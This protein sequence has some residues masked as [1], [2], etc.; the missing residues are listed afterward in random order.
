MTPRGSHICTS[1]DSITKPRPVKSITIQR[2]SE[3]PLSAKKTSLA[4][5]LCALC[6]FLTLTALASSAQ[7]FTTL[8]NF[9]LTDGANP[10]SGSLAQ[11]RD[12]SFYGT[13]V[14]GG[15]NDVGTVFRLTPT[16]VIATIHS[17]DGSDGAYPQPGALLQAPDGYFYGTAEAGG[18]DDCGTVFKIGT[19]G[20]LTTLHS[21]NGHDGKAPVGALVLAPN[22]NFY[23][24]TAFGGAKNAGT[25]FS[26]TPGG[27][28]TTLHSFNIRDGQY[29]E[30][31]LVAAADGEFYGTT[32]F[33]G[34]YLGDDCISANNQAVQCGTIFKITPAGA[35]TTV[36][37]FNSTDGFS[38][39]GLIQGMDGNF[40]G[41]TY[42]GGGNSIQAGTVYRITS[43]G[44]LTTLYDFC[45]G[46]NCLT[47]SSPY[48]A[49]VQGTW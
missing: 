15:A 18:P 20:A 14:A 43:T 36:H 34:A 23:G 40:Y 24:A 49:L 2:A 3:N 27:T 46:N 45:A 32:V 44:T 6:A 7:T 48:D 12:G 22:G 42:G 38:P 1:E 25:I 41:T 21:F 28:L 4:A 11:G 10:A 26:M 9:D 29:P 16:G 17:F 8:V 19:N 13:T 35:F 5:T 39:N 37:S 30:S 47:G 31:G 33:G